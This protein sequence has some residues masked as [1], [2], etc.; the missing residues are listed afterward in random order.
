MSNE[1]KPVGT[2]FSCNTSDPHIE[3]LLFGDDTTSQIHTDITQ[4]TIPV[5]TPILTSLTFVAEPVNNGVYDSPF[6]DPTRQFCW[7]H[8]THLELSHI[9]IFPEE[10]RGILERAEAL[11]SLILHRP[12]EGDGAPQLRASK[13][14]VSRTLDILQLLKC[15]TS[16]H[17]FLSSAHVDLAVS[18]LVLQTDVTQ[19]IQVSH[20]GLRW[21]QIVEMKLSE[22]FGG[23]FIG[24]C[25]VNL[26]V[27]STLH[28]IPN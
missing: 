17:G 4:V 8:L 21:G 23:N 7:T 16:I 28:I 24:Q 15:K 25:Q 10:Y 9:S 2:F 20:L 19:D 13:R 11:N 3:R 14:I 27:G 26:S 12:G 18:K 5:I 6:R 1:L 22:R